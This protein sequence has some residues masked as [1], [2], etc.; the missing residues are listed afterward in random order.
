MLNLITF[1]K[2]ISDNEKQIQIIFAIFAAGY[3][4]FEYQTKVTQDHIANSINKVNRY[5]QDDKLSKS[6][7]NLDDFFNKN[8]NNISA[9]EVAEK[10]KASGKEKDVYKVMTFYQSIELCVKSKQCDTQTMC[11]YFFTDIQGF[12]ENYRAILD[13]YT[14]KGDSAPKDLSIF[15]TEQCKKEI[16]QYC[17]KDVPKSP[18]CDQ[19]KNLT[20][21]TTMWY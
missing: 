1:W 2:W 9:N 12:Q 10:I 3:I 16:Y 19:I 17:K 11:D 5:E 15:T 7:E 20:F 13:E 8:H 6:L 14:K 18:D 4:I 21:I